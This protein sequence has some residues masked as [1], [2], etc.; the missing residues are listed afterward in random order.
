MFGKAEIK[1]DAVEIAPREKIEAFG[2]V[3]AVT[4]SISRA[5]A[6]RDAPCSA[7]SSSMTSKRF[8]LGPHNA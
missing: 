6:C 1:H 2:P 7:A 3:P 5:R 4:I 8:R